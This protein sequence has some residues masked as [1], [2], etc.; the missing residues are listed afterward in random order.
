MVPQLLG[1]FTEG[2]WETWLIVHGIEGRAKVVVSIV[3]LYDFFFIFHSI[4]GCFATLSV[5]GSVRS[6]CSNAR[7]ETRQSAAR[8]AFPFFQRELIHIGDATDT[9]L[10][11]QQYFPYGPIP[12]EER[13][14]RMA[15]GT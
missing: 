12:L 9:D 1:W 11:I 6:S 15:K 13:K 7:S 14:G 10:R 2:Q 8:P 5:Q 3:Y 4:F